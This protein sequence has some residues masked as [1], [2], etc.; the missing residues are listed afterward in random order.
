MIQRPASRHAR[1]PELVT[2][3]HEHDA[4]AGRIAGR[5]SGPLRQAYHDLLR[6]VQDTSRADE[7]QRSY[8]KLKR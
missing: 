8:L 1:Q 2:R 6:G 5:P 3:P 4:P 7:A